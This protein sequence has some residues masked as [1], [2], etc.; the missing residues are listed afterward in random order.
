MAAYLATA[1]VGKFEVE[2]YTTRDGIRVYNAV[3]PRAAAASASVLKK[4]PSVLEWESKL[5]GPYPF[6][7]AGSVVD[8]A[9]DVGFALETQSRPLYDSAPDLS[10]LV[11]E[12]AHSSRNSA[13]T[14]PPTPAGRASGPPS[15]PSPSPRGGAS[16]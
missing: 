16:P 8:D 15:A 9:P 10:T 11:R 14:P 7:D 5:F 1:T 12:N 6:H 2:Q 4:L 3:D 13:A